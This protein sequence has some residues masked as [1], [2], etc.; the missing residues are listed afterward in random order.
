MRKIANWFI[1]V[2]AYALFVA[3]NKLISAWDY[4]TMRNN[5]DT[6]FD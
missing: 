4:I 2:G 6:R 1:G 5:E 3:L